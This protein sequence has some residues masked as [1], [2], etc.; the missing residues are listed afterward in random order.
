[1]V[2]SSSFLLS[3]PFLLSS[4]FSP[5]IP[6]LLTLLSPPLFSSSIRSFSSSSRNMTE[7][8]EA[9]RKA[10]IATTVIHAGQVR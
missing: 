6:H 1:M 7:T 9:E 4:F 3:L 10:N 5:L 8:K 2:S